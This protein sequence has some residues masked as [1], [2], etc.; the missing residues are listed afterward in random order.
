MEVQAREVSNVGP[1]LDAL[2]VQAVRGE[3]LEDRVGGDRGAL[4]ARARDAR[5]VDVDRGTD[6][7]ALEWGPGACPGR[8]TR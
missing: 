8:S 5:V 3:L 1:V 4:L 6:V 7:R 2:A